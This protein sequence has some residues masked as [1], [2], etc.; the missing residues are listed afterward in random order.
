MRGSN[1]RP[2]PL[3]GGGV[4]VGGEAS[5]LGSHWRSPDKC[6]EFAAQSIG[7]FR[8]LYVYFIHKHLP[9]DLGKKDWTLREMAGF[10]DGEGDVFRLEQPTVGARSFSY[11]IEKRAIDFP[12]R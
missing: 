5:T 1:R 4:Y 6:L 10:V 8:N 2:E 11:L 7:I 3:R 12:S 9:I